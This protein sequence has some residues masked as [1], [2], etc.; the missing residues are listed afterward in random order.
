LNRVLLTNPAEHRLERLATPTV[1]DNRISS[2]CINVPAEFFEQ[3][4][5]PVFATYRAMVYILPEQ[6]SLEEVFGP[7]MPG[8]IIAKN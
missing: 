4:V 1:A 5:L 8:R 2:G 7:V 3:T 6:K